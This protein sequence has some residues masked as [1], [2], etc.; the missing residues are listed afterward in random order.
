M[1]SKVKTTGLSWL[2]ITILVVLVDR[3]TKSA[4]L[5]Y[6]VAYTPLGMT[7]FFNLTLAF[8]KGAAFSFLDQNTVWQ[9]WLFGSISLIVSVAI[10]VWL[11]RIPAQ[12]RWL[13]IALTLVLAGALGNLTDRILY[14]HVIDFLDFHLGYWHWPAFNV[15]DSAI[16]IGAFMLL[17][18]SFS[19]KK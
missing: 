8:N 5:K 12:K 15:A 9:G 3:L 4:A 16:C 18:D 6:L 11:A 19:T 13:G 7:Q 2:W 10:L 17:F 14:G 1:L